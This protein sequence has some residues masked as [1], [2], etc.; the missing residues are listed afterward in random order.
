MGEADNRVNITVNIQDTTVTRAGFG[1]LAIVHEHGVVVAGR[2]ATYSSLSALQAVHPAYT[3]VGQFANIFFSQAF[4]PEEIKV[5]KRE[6]AES[7]TQALTAAA[8]VDPDWYAIGVP[9]D[10]SADHQS[11]ASYALANKKLYLYSSQEAA[12]ITSATTDIFS[13]L[14]AATNNRAGGWFS[15]TAGL[16]MTI[17]SLTVVG[18]TCTADITTFVTAFGSNPLAIGD[19]VGI[20]DSATS[21]LN[22]IWTALTVGANDFTFTVP[23]GTASDAT[24]SSAWLNFNL[25]DAA[26]SGKMLPLDAGSR[27]WDMQILS[28]VIVD[29]RGASTAT[30]L[31]DTEKGF[32]A[33]KNANWFAQI[34]GN[35]ATSG[36][37]PGGGGK[38]AS[39]RY[40]DVQRGAD[41]LEANLQADLV[42]LILNKGGALG[43]DADGFQNVEATIKTRLDEGLDKGFLTPFVSGPYAGQNYAV[44]MPNLGTIPSADKTARL[45]SD[46][47]IYALIRGKI[48]N[49]EATITLATA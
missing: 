13:V 8:L 20:W 17:D 40:I 31:T 42:Q 37:K 9:G 26:I 48:H 44:I 41:W 32:L 10:V 23:S 45:L 7:V 6:T 47:E 24:A 22:T 11:A 25:I 4:V 30:V 34:A 35:N 33:D 38:L 36:P 21:A 5:I 1:T 43:Y 49:L 29:G 14:Q 16:E 46:I 2:V 39:G 12:A 18:T 19:T 15:K 27:T 28:G 3:P